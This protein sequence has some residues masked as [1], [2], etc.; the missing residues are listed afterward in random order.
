MD[1]RR[2]LVGFVLSVVLCLSA[3][4]V[5][6]GQGGAVLAVSTNSLDLGLIGTV[7]SD[8][9][10]YVYNAGGEDTCFTWLIADTDECWLT[11]TVAEGSDTTTCTGEE[12]HLLIEVDPSCLGGGGPESGSFE[13][14][15]P[16]GADIYETI[17]VSFEYQPPSGLEV[18]KT[19]V[20][21]GTITGL[22]GDTSVYVYN[23]PP[24]ASI[25]WTV[26]E[27]VAW[28]TVSPMSGTTTTEQDT[29]TI[30]VDPA[31]LTGGQSYSDSF[32]VTRDGTPSDTAT[33]NVSFT[34]RHS[35]PITV[36]GTPPSGSKSG[37]ITLAGAAVWYR[38]D[39]P[40]GDT[41]LWNLWTDVGVDTIL[42]LYTA[43]DGTLLAENDN[44]DAGACGLDHSPL[45]SRIDYELSGGTRYFL[46]VEAVGGATGNYTV[47]VREHVNTPPELSNGSV[48][49]GS[50]EN[51]T[52]FTYS[53]DYYDMDADAPATKQVVIDGTPHP[54][55]LQSG[56]AHDGTYRYQA[57]GEE[58][59]MGDHTYYFSFTD[60]EGGTARLPAS[61]TKSGPT[62]TIE[63][64]DVPVGFWAYN[65]IQGCV[66][67]GVVGGYPD[68]YYHPEMDV[69]RDQMAV[70]VARADRGGE[71][72]VPAGP[73]E[74]TFNDVP[75]DHWAYK[76]V[77]YCV[78]EYIVTGYGAG[79]Y[80]PTV[81]VTRDQM[82]VYIARALVGGESNVP[83]GWLIPT[84]NDVPAGSWAY[85]HVEYCHDQGV[86]SGYPDGL[87]HPEYTVTR[88]Q[89][90]VYIAR[91]FMTP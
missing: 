3:A 18:N 23:A 16:G 68:G 56:E 12:D 22:A 72:N 39:V 74:A 85:N 91:A 2:S 14:R 59:G 83:G 17:T 50:G 63:F 67:G 15:R 53:V 48:T 6:R 87:Y 54:M 29:L 5:A 89:M 19:N 4:A 13:V 88:D 49:P 60:G 69:A 38:F 78:A 75:T 73:P 57:T 37:S 21:L 66:M 43:V 52:T 36:S 25:D 40:A 44:C 47:H 46:K 26:T 82:A 71:A 35:I 81:P 30:T 77:E 45:H 10:V 28:L 65:E 24:P 79:T 58:L 76:H 32:T 31:G 51:T 34:F 8:S 70:F 11:V 64:P 42:G 1:T 9:S 33:V 86:V 84:F 80:A 27:S 7:T 90:A 62:V 41:E 55:A 61:G 20:D